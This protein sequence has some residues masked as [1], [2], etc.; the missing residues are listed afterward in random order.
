MANQQVF[1]AVLPRIGVFNNHAPFVEF[2]VKAVALSY[3]MGIAGNVGLN[4]PFLTN[5]P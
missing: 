4:L 3:R 5:Q 2:F 1:K